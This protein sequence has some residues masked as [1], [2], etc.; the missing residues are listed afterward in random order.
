MIII[1][2]NKDDDKAFIF[3][4][5]NPHGVE[6]TRYMKSKKSLYAI[7]CH[8]RF[9]PLFRGDGQGSDIAIYDN[10]NK[11]NSCWIMNDGIHGYECHPEYKCSLFVNTAGPNKKN[12]FSVLDYEVYTHE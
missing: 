3:T 1:V 6:P 2:E 8:P 11:K 7:C 10:C 5:K 4:L 12:L 9:G